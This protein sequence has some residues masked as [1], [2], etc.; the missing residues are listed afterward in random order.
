[1][2][3]HVIEAGDNAA[4]E[5]VVHLCALID[6]FLPDY[7]IT[8]GSTSSTSYIYTLQSHVL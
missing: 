3:S 8:Y 5:N 7:P 4:H 1:M 6:H 2:K